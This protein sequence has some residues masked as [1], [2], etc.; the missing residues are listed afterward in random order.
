MNTHF[1]IGQKT[2]VNPFENVQF[3]KL[4][5]ISLVFQVGTGIEK[6]SSFL[7]R[8]SKSVETRKINDRWIILYNIEHLN[9]T[10]LVTWYGTDRGKFYIN[11]SS[12]HFQIEG[13]ML[14]CW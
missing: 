5:N 8:K 10:T 1:N 2:V 12:V 6:L 11:N 3:V 9:F 7:N 13:D 4:S 14:C